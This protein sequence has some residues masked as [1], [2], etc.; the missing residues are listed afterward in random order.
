MKSRTWYK[1]YLISKSQRKYAEENHEL[2]QD[3]EV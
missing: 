1:T 3:I 2:K